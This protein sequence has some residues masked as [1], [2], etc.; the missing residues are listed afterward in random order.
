MGD[1]KE[2]VVERTTAPHVQPDT[3]RTETSSAAGSLLA[4]QRAAGN[5]AASRLAAE[6]TRVTVQ[7]L[8]NDELIRRFVTY[9][10]GAN[11]INNY[12]PR[13][14]D[15]RGAKKGLSTMENE[16]DY[17]GQKAQVIE[18]DDLGDDLAAV[19]NGVGQNDSHVSIVPSDDADDAKLVEWASAKG[20]EDIEHDL[21]AAVMAARTG[22][23]RRPKVPK[24]KK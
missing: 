3:R 16:A 12:T 9:R 23:V 1:E 4:V 17:L 7:S 2:A 19:R 13:D 8:S 22:E 24:K 5:R 21:S 14:K 11:T 15:T 18:T 20:Q 6:H 10:S